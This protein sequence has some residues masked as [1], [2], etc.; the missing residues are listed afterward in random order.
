MN[1][2]H[3]FRA[4]LSIAPMIDWSNTHFRFWMRLL[5][6][7]A[8][9]YTEMQT[10]GAVIHR[11]DKALFFDPREA[12]VAIQL[13]GSDPQQLAQCA[14]MAEQR[15]FVEINLNLGCPSDRVQAGHFGACL[16]QHPQL[17]AECIAAMQ[18]VVQIPV[19]AKVRIGIDQQDSFEF[20]YAFTR[21]L[22]D[23]GCDKLIVHARKAWLKGLSPKQNRSIPPLQYDYV[24][25]LKTLLPAI[26]IIINGNIQSFDEVQN[27]LAH[28]DGVMLGRLACQDPYQIARI[29]AGVYPEHTMPSRMDVIDAYWDYMRY[30]IEEKNVPLTVLTKHLYNFACAMPYAKRWKAFLQ[31]MQQQKKLL[32]PMPLL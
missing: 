23:V 1:N 26:P 9:L 31:T 11:P 20:F 4:P 14:Q 30:Q 27:H 29:H 12:P 10:T 17:V 21:T 28:V 18:S 13:G 8:L 3:A 22:V 32:Q 2:I 16:M 25:Q 7:Q 6:P 5:A 19:T 15:G 24:Y